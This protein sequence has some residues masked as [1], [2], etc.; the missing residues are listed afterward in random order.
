M[1]TLVQIVLP[2]LVVFTTLFGL[3]SRGDPR[4]GGV[5]LFWRVGLTGLFAGAALWYLTFRT[6]ALAATP[7][8]V[9]DLYL[10]LLLGGGILTLFA[11]LGTSLKN[12]R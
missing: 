2:A 5:A 4:P 9:R 11:A 3:L 8:F 12:K 7:A 10:G 1:Q 6:G